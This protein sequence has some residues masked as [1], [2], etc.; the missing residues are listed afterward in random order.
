M[1]DGMTLLLLHDQGA[2]S[3][4]A[5]IH[6]LAYHGDDGRY[7]IFA[8]KGGAPTNPAWYH[9]LKAHPEA[10]IEVGTDTIEVTASELT[11]EERDRV[12]RAQAQRAPQ[13]AEYEQKTKRDDPGDRP[14]PEAGELAA[15]PGCRAAADGERGL[16]AGGHRVVGERLHG[17]AGGR[18][19]SSA[20]RLVA[21][22]RVDR[23]GQAGRESSGAITRPV[24]PS[25]TSPP[26]AAPTAV[27]AITV[28][29]CSNA[30][31]QTRPQGSLKRGVGIE[32]TTV[33]CAAA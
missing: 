30:S 29:P 26:A 19:E 24:S 21:E 3:G 11:G 10:R 18:A 4:K 23:R 20:Q 5:H 31:L 2:K 6:P 7:V 27:V 14:D 1:F 17:G 8:S 12:F 16:D 15:A 25:R 22:Q 33:N 32:G 13:F 9:N 28:R